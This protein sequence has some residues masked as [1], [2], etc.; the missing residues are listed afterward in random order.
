[1][2]RR[3]IWLAGLFLFAAALSSAATEVVILRGGTRIELASPMVRQGNVMV[4]TRLDGT[5][6][7]VPVSEVDLAATAALKS[8]SPTPA[9]PEATPLPAGF[10]SAVRPGGSGARART[11]ITDSDVGHNSAASDPAIAG[12]NP[13]SAG[14]NSGANANINASGSGDP[15]QIRRTLAAQYQEMGNG[16]RTAAKAAERLRILEQIKERSLACDEQNCASGDAEACS[17]AASGL[18]SRGQ[19]A[20][21]REYLEKACRAGRKLDCDALQAAGPALA[22]MDDIR[23][24]EEKRCAG[25]GAAAARSCTFVGTLYFGDGLMSQ[26]RDHYQT[27]CNGGDGK[28]C[29]NLAVVEARLGHTSEAPALLEKACRLGFLSACHRNLASI[30]DPWN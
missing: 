6:F 13:K 18:F 8:I 15:C 10:A 22:K 19:A 4:L 24:Q 7:S 1:M 20:A 5:V 9:P 27:A 11:R 26:A 12:G 2:L 30:T 14:T 23:V 16:P 3:K 25:S 28:G 21:A 17:Q 29:A